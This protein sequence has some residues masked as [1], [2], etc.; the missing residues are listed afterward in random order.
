[1]KNY[2]DFSNYIRKIQEQP[3][4]DNTSQLLH[5]TFLSYQAGAS[6]ND[7]NILKKSFYL[8]N[9]VHQEY[10]FKKINLQ[11][12]QL[13]Y[14]NYIN[15]KLN[16]NLEVPDIAL[17]NNSGSQLF[18]TSVIQNKDHISIVQQQSQ[19]QNQIKV[20]ENSRIE[21]K[22]ENPLKQNIQENLVFEK[23]A[24]Q[25]IEQIQKSNVQM[26]EKNGN[27]EII[28]SIIQNDQSKVSIQIPKIKE[29]YYLSI[30]QS[31]INKKQQYQEYRKQESQKSQIF[32]Q[33]NQNSQIKQ[34]NQCSIC[35]EN[36]I[37]NKHILIA[38]QHIYHKQCLENLINASVEFP[39]R[40][41]NLECRQEILRD[42][43]E[44]IVSN[45][46]MD[47]LEKIAFNQYLLQNSNIFQCPTENCKGVY[48]IEGPIQVCM[49]CQNLFCTRCKKQFHEGVC[50]EQSFI[51]VALEK[52]YKQCSKCHRWIDKTF[53]CNHMTCPCGFQF[54]YSCGD[55]WIKGRECLCKNKQQQNNIDAQQIPND[56]NEIQTFL[57]Q[58]NQNQNNTQKIDKVLNKLGLSFVK[59]ILKK[60]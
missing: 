15:G 38:C 4:V 31:Q 57:N 2:F 39:I 43:L 60:W 56:F 58:N 50:G 24:D 36:V 45:Q 18:D 53:G 6:N 35:L 9:Q 25:S 20:Q 7:P 28:D 41:P 59:K 52:N 30:D 32:S 54:C 14:N 46:I 48:E 3:F 16:I 40:C 5:M 49:I 47:K 11:E 37:Q 55:Q 23:N 42:D 44:N 26:L 29:I 34:T 19:S 8:I 10:V 21:Y 1:M 17:Q 33:I 13:I 51:N 27:R 22:Q 12:L